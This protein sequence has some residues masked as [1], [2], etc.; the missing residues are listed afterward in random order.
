MTKIKWGKNK[1][2]TNLDLKDSKVISQS[3][4]EESCTIKMLNATLI[5]LLT[6]KYYRNNY[7]RSC[8]G[9]SLMNQSQYD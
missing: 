6:K 3:Q 4:V 2:N 1:W 8:L 9:L 7:N 5:N